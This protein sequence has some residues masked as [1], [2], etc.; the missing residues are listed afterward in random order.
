MLTPVLYTAQ[1]GKDVF[2]DEEYFRTL[3]STK[4]QFKVFDSDRIT[5]SLNSGNS[6]AY[7][8]TVTHNLGYRPQVLAWAYYVDAKSDDSAMEVVARFTLIPYA[9][10]VYN[11]AENSPVVASIDRSNTQVSFKFYEQ[12]ITGMA[13]NWT[14]SN[15]RLMYIIFVDPE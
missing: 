4:N 3:D 13:N 6:Y 11:V 9:I 1:R 7:T 12:P 2:A 10:G 14:A 8:K 15:L 5:F